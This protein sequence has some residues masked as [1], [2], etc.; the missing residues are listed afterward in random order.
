M[1]CIISA[2]V[3]NGNI[4]DKS[5]SDSR[6][7]KYSEKSV[8]SPDFQALTKAEVILQ[9]D[10]HSSGNGNGLMCSSFFDPNKKTIIF[11]YEFMTP[12]GNGSKSTV[13]DV[14][15]T[16]TQ[17]HYAAKVYRKYLI[18]STYSNENVQIPSSII[19]EIEIMSTLDHHNVLPLMEV[20]DDETT[21]AIILIV[22]LAKGGNLLKN[23]VYSEE[24]AKEIVR[25]IANG[26]LYIHSLNIIHRDIKPD[27]ILFLED[28]HI[29][30]A[31]F[32]VSKLL[33]DPCELLDDTVGA[34][35]FYSPEICT[36]EKYLGKPADC[37]SLGILMY[38]ILFGHHPFC[39][40]NPENNS[41][42][43]ILGRIQT[44]DIAYP[45]CSPQLLDLLSGILEKCPEKRLTIE[46]IVQHKWMQ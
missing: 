26:I 28:N 23:I 5:I 6:L 41:S 10:I 29:V 24:K 32:S 18:R 35:P 4:G 25:Q 8:E 2:S 21:Q 44:Q 30:I 37:W 9:E 46:Q 27:N 3:E 38:L 17:I 19:G 42:Y 12:I 34:I 13:Y 39:S 36:G 31:D 20:I 14:L 7:T 15:D 33:N 22:P 40:N 43:S 45:E 11:N 16:D 1:G